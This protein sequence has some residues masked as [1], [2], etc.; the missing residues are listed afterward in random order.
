MYTLGTT[1]VASEPDVFVT[2][3][4]SAIA[5]I[6]ADGSGISY[7]DGILTL[8]GCAGAVAKVISMNGAV[9]A[10]FE[11]QAEAS[12]FDLN[13]APGVYIVSV[14]GNGAQQAAKIVIR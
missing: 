10:T 11:C 7:A 1:E 14:S 4:T 5:G 2:D 8:P 12:V 13:V 9:C 6:A 3:G